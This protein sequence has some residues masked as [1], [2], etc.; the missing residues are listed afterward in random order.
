M[1]KLYKNL[2]MA[3]EDAMLNPDKKERLDGEKESGKA[4]YVSLEKNEMTGEYDYWLYHGN[5]KV[6]MALGASY[7]CLVAEVFA[8]YIKF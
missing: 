2:L 4:Y 5:Q 3:L 6:T 7:I 8:Q 1:N